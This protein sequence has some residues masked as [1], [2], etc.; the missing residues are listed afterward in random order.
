[1]Y[2]LNFIALATIYFE[3]ESTVLPQIYLIIIWKHIKKSLSK[4]ECVFATPAQVG[5]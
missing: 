1:M 4:I 5:L 3:I 2:E